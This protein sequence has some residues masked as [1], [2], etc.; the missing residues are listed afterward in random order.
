MEPYSEHR[1]VPTTQKYQSEQ[2]ARE[3]EPQSSKHRLSPHSPPGP[4]GPERPNAKGEKAEMMNKMADP[5]MKPTEKVK[6]SRAGSI[7]GVRDPT[8]GL[9]VDIKDAD[10]RGTMPD[11]HQ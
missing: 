4:S 2:Q 7:R 3:N 5:K 8:T 10:F 1:P 6:K 11:A 9:D